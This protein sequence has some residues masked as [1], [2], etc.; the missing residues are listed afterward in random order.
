MR[1]VQPNNTARL[2]DIHAKLQAIKTWQLL[3]ILLISML[4]AATFLRLNNLGMAEKRDAVIAA[5][6]AGDKAAIKQSL[7]DLQKYVSSHMNTDL[8]NGVYL[9]TTYERDRDAALATATTGSN[10]QSAVYQQASVECRARFQGGVESFRNDYVQCVLQRVAALSASADPS[11]GLVL[12]KADSYRYDF[13]SPAWTP[14]LAGLS[15]FF[16]VLV[17]TVI[18][19]RLLALLALRLLIRHRYRSI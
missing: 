19:G 11:A 3:V 16:C 1:W 4:I 14:D 2:R 18:V 10:P 17:T 8:G 5:D 9:V 12:P 7:I 6:K 13:S 15:V